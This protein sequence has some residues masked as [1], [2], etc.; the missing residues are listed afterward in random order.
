V[1]RP[2][3]YVVEPKRVESFP[4]ETERQFRLLLEQAPDSVFL[5]GLDG[6]FVYVNDEACASLGYSRDELLR[7]H[8]WDFVLSDSRE[9]IVHLWQDM[10]F[11][12]LS[13]ENTHVTT[14]T[15]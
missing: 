10:V 2:G 3:Q 8:P 13:G 15:S 9:Y 7:M 4:W 5:H 1:T 6:R 12:D 11:A 14:V